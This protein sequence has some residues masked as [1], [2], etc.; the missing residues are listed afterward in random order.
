VEELWDQAGV[1]QLSAAT[2]LAI[3]ILLVLTGRLVPR[4]QVEDLREDRDRRIREISSERDTWRLVAEREAAARA[5]LQ[6]STLELQELSRTAVH[7]LSALPTPPGREVKA[8]APL[9][10]LPPPPAP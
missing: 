7:L 4:R 1:L 5:Q 9:G 6:E 8:G 10:P 2:I 3:V